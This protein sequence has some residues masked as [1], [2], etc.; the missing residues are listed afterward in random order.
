MN[1][2]RRTERAVENLP[3]LGEAD[4]P[5]TP[6]AAPPAALEARS[7]GHAEQGTTS[8][9]T[10]VPEPEAEADSGTDA[11]WDAYDQTLAAATRERDRALDK[12]SSRLASVT[13]GGYL[14]YDRSV[15]MAWAAYDAT[16]HNARLTHAAQPR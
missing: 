5:V 11:T 14:E 10:S 4:S 16:T 13:Q 12:A 3:A 8:L 15:S 9:E 1:P 7:A 6:A 2:P